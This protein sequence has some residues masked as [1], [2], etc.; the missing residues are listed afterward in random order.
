MS[1]IAEIREGEIVSDEDERWLARR[2]SGGPLANR[3]TGTVWGN[4]IVRK[5]IE[6]AR[7]VVRAEEELLEA[8]RERELSAGR[9]SRVGAEIEAEGLEMENRRR[10]AARRAKTAELQ[11]QLAQKQLEWELLQLKK[12][13]QELQ[14]VEDHRSS[15]QKRLEEAEEKAR[16]ETERKVM[17]AKQGVE[18]ARKLRAQRDAMIAEVLGGRREEDAT[19]EER[20]TIED[21]RDQ[22]QFIIDGL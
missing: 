12:A 17:Q 20:T 4:T 6:S 15:Y 10:E 8:L 11:D 1:V 2:E 3:F 7:G 13:T 14:G 22:F 21:I 5:R 9:L 18:T 16:F 19:G